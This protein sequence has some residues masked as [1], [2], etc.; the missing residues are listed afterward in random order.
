M[1]VSHVECCDCMEFMARYPDKHFELA[2][3]DPPYNHPRFGRPSSR[4]EK[5]G[6]YR[7]WNKNRPKQNYFELLILKS[8]NQIV[9]GGNYFADCL[10]ITQG[11]IVWNKANPAPSFADGEMAW[12]SIDRPLVIF[13]LHYFSTINSDECRIHPTQKPVAL[14]KWLLKNYA[15]PGDKILDTHLGSGSSRIAAWDMGFDF[16]G[17]ELDAE[18]FEASCK[19]FERF[20][21]QLKLDLTV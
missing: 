17:C 8:K 13:N 5:Y 18:Y 10:K 7:K 14:Y 2:I 4:I 15:K 9:W 21:A 11:W 16:Y 3:V 1:P 19:R 6:N 12:T 20:K